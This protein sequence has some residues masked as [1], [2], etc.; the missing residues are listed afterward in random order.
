MIKVSV[1]YPN[2]PQARFDMDYY[3]QRHIPLVQRLCGAELKSV[4]V[5]GGVAGATPGSA[6]SFLA[7]GHLL[8]DSVEAFQGSFGP[9]NREIVAD[10]P[11]YTNIQPVIQISQ[12]MM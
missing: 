3:R 8:F 10:V 1:F 4:A 7:M 12:V 11:N 5:E 9:H 2:G 6:P